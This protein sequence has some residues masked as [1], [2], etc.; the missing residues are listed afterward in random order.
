MKSAGVLRI[1]REIELA[2][3]DIAETELRLEIET[4]VAA[5]EEALARSA[6]QA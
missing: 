2:G 5:A 4:E 6:G 1:P 3:L